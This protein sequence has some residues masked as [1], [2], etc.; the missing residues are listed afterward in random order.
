MTCGGSAVIWDHLR[1]ARRLL[2]SWL[3]IQA[4]IWKFPAAE[5]RPDV[6]PYVYDVARMTPLLLPYPELWWR[7]TLY[8]DYVNRT[9]L[10]MLSQNSFLHP[11]CFPRW[12]SW[13]GIPG[14]ASKCVQLPPSSWAVLVLLGDPKLDSF[15]TV[16]TQLDLH[17]SPW[18]IWLMSFLVHR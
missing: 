6:R 2:H 10:L 4:W 8:V 15:W 18:L 7:Y 5:M 3:H 14:M 16:L 9:L 13:C 1:S 11:F 17:H 12:S